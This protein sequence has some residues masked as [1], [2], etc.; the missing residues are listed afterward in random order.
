MVT[1]FATISLPTRHTTT[2]QLPAIV[3]HSSLASTTDLPHLL[4]GIRTHSLKLARTVHARGEPHFAAVARAVT[5]LPCHPSLPSSGSRHRSSKTSKALGVRSTFSGGLRPST[6]CGSAAADDKLSHEA[7]EPRA[8]AAGAADR[9]RLAGA[10][11][12]LPWST[13]RPC[14]SRAETVAEAAVCSHA[15]ASA[16]PHLR[17]ASAS[18]SPALMRRLRTLVGRGVGWPSAPG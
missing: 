7:S 17:R 5:P 8:T 4:R 14:P 2:V 11:V 9:A 16:P 12:S 15:D 13:L 18:R 6:C 3:L 10:A 1:S